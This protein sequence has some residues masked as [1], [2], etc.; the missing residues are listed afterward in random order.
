MNER[1]NRLHELLDKKEVRTLKAH[2]GTYEVAYRWEVRYM[3]GL[4]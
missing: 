1:I 2:G 4:G 3:M